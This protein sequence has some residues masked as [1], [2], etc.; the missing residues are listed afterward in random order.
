[1]L[2]QEALGH[3]LRAGGR[4]VWCGTIQGALHHL[5]LANYDLWHSLSLFSFLKEEARQIK[6]TSRSDEYTARSAPGEAASPM[7]ARYTMAS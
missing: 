3:G 1:M 5:K 7:A 6:E 4:C 2:A